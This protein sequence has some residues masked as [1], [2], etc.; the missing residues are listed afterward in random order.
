VSVPFEEKQDAQNENCTYRRPGDGGFA[1]RP[2]ARNGA[3]PFPQGVSLEPLKTEPASRRRCPDCAASSMERD[4]PSFSATNDNINV[5]SGASLNPG[6]S[7]DSVALQGTG[8]YLG[9]L[10]GTGYS[11]SGTD[12]TIDTW[13]DTGLKVVGNNDGINVG[14][15]STVI[16]D[17]SGDDVDGV[18]VTRETVLACGRIECN[19]APGDRGDVSCSASYSTAAV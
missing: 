12:D 18:A 8:D 9:L 2:D 5:V 19:A 6:G 3:G 10:G 1:R 13:A 11:V 14:D 7:S 16:S 17:G 15:D 4:R